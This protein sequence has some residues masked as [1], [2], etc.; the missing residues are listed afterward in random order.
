MGPAAGR[1]MKRVGSV[2][3]RSTRS[4]VG[5][6]VEHRRI[7]DAG[8]AEP[9][10]LDVRCSQHADDAWRR[11]AGRGRPFEV[12]SLGMAAA[13]LRHRRCH[14]ARVVNG[15]EVGQARCVRHAAPATP[16]TLPTPMG[17]PCRGRPATRSRLPRPA[18]FFLVAA[19]PAA[20]PSR[21]RHVTPTLCDV[22][23]AAGRDA[24]A[25]RPEVRDPAAG[26]AEAV[27]TRL[28]RRCDSGLGEWATHEV[29]H[30]EFAARCRWADRLGVAA[31]QRFSNTPARTWGLRLW[32]ADAARTSEA[33]DRSVVF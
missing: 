28:A 1:T 14:R 3:V 10:P 2:N 26:L 33:S 29:R 27:S 21:K 25:G 19:R 15:D 9:T 12:S 11:S 23:V 6:R 31:G 16:A 5:R 22:G 30:G 20:D 17:A 32:A 18:H 13:V 8:L 4:I 7:S 24:R